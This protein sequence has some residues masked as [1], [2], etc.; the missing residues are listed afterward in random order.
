MSMLWL[1][2]LADA[3]Q[4]GAI[5]FTYFRFACFAPGTLR[6]FPDYLLYAL[7]RTG[8]WRHTRRKLE[9]LVETSVRHRKMFPREIISKWK[10]WVRQAHLVVV[11]DY[12]GEIFVERM[13]PRRL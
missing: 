8:A 5:A 10:V 1:R 2:I 7:E 11:E 4:N 13:A 3:L 12:L 9:A 6:V